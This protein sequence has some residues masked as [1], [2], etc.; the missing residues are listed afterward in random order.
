MITID[1]IGDQSEGSIVTAAIKTAAGTIKVMAEV[2]LEDPCLI[3]R[4]FHIEGV[5][6]GV[7]DIRPAG[8]RRMVQEVMEE[9]DVQEII[10]EGSRRTTGAN[11][12]RTPRRLRFTRKV[13]PAE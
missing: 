4:R 11:P 5:D 1:L 7:N 12:G 8:L 10:M 6:V 9:L 2:I 3:L 13:S